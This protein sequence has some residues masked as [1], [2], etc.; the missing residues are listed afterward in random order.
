MLDQIL[1]YVVFFAQIFL[2]SYYLPGK[3]LRR[4]KY[5]LET[6]PPSGYS[7]LY[8]KPIG[9]Y[10]KALRN[11]KTI[12]G[13]ILLVGLLL[14]AVMFVYSKGGEWDIVF[15]YFMIQFIPMLLLEIGSFNMYKLMRKASTT[16]KAE[17]HPR[18]LLDF[19]SPRLIGLAV[20]VYLAFIA[21]VV[22]MRQ[23]E[24]PWFGGYENVAVMTGMNLFLAGI[25]LWNIYGKKQDPYQAYEDRKRHIDHF[26][27]Q[28]VFVSISATLFGII[29]VVIKAI[30]LDDFDPM[31][32]SLYFQLIAV[33]SLRAIRIDKIDF[34]V[35][36]S[37]PSQESNE[38][39][40]YLISEETAENDKHSPIYKMVGLSFGLSFGIALAFKEGAT[41]SGII[42]IGGV[43]GGIGLILGIGF[44]V[45]VSHLRQGNSSMI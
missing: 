29:Q 38:E 9:Y 19:I 36:K 26:A 2:I 5:V 1:F 13:C 17:L 14:M 35:Y 24:Y 15:P 27:K 30:D 20:L 28:M 6:Y 18:R 45:W 25:L 12:N 44:G 42:L 22:Y 34:E 32:M 16:R 40:S 3:M 7:K 37:D 21:F 41:I 8:P 4:M 23:F 33:I 31:I 43:G 10:E 39:K 11:F